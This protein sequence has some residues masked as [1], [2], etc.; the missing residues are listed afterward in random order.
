MDVEDGKP[1][2][3]GGGRVRPLCT[4][5]RHPFPLKAYTVDFHGG[6]YCTTFAV[7]HRFVQV[8]VLRSSEC[9]LE[10]SGSPGVDILVFSFVLGIREIPTSSSPA[11]VPG[12]RR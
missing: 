6:H 3:P 11:V 8:L 4:P 1:R 9:I 5:G 12:R 10:E 7:R 2:A